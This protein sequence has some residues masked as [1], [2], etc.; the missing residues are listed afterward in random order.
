MELSYLSLIVV[1][2]VLG[3]GTQW[4][5]NHT[6]KHWSKVPLDMRSSG[7]RIARDFLDSEGLT[8]VPIRPNGG[9]ELSDYYDPRSNA[10]YLSDASEHGCSVASV[11]VA[12]HEAG[13]A[14]QHERG[15]MPARIRMALVP[16]V[17]IG[18]E[19][20]MI[21]LLLGIFINMTPLVYLGIILF[22]FVVAFQLVTLPVEFDA[23]ARA[24]R[25]IGADPR[26]SAEQAAGARKVL[27]AAALT[28]VAA[29]LTSVLQLVYLLQQRNDD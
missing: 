16:A 22:A 9:P 8:G 18:S 12:C 26:I 1:S 25:Y 27:T 21:V 28:Y 11:A 14:V 3:L 19:A 4:Y 17:N 15:Y 13:H 5:I 20:W 23:S 24:M 7:S 10:L 2:L 29:A 6:Y